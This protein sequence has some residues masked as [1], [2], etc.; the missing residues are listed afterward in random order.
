MQCLEKPSGEWNIFLL[1]SFHLH[2][3][4]F[5][6]MQDLADVAHSKVDF[7]VFPEPPATLTDDTGLCVFS[8]LQYGV[9]L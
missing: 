5:C 6:P 8:Q 7:S 3:T 4:L 1:C 9:S 2:S